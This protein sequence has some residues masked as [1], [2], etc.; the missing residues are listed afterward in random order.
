MSDRSQLALVAF[1][2]ATTAHG[3]SMQM[4]GKL[5]NRATI[6]ILINV[7]RFVRLP[8]CTTA[9]HRLNHFAPQSG[10]WRC[11]AFRPRAFSVRSAIGRSVAM[12]C[13]ESGWTL[14]DR[15]WTDGECG[16][17]PQA[18]YYTEN[19]LSK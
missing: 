15:D 18:D 7:L 13:D 1:D 2:L 17:I 5:A 9:E 12:G 8:S 19:L 16:L 14:T 10:W 6:S 3:H 11:E 4:L